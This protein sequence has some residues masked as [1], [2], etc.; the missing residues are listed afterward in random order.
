VSYNI[1]HGVDD[2]HLFEMGRVFHFEE[3]KEHPTE[4]ERLTAVLS[5][6]WCGHTWH[7]KPE[8]LDFFD[9]KGVVEN[10]LRELAVRKVAFKA[11]EAQATPWL[12]GGRA[13]WV[14]SS[15]RRLGWLG[16]VH[17]RVLA[18]FDID[19]S[20]VAFE[21]DVEALRSAS[22]DAREYVDIPQYPAVRLDLSLLLAKE[23]TAMDVGRA[24]KSAGG[25]L[26]REV[27][28]F[29]VFEDAERLG[30]ERRSMAFSLEYRAAD[31]TLSMDEVEKVHGRLVE[32]VVKATGAEIR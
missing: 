29:D 15:K 21:F 2:V 13:A 27:T 18:A 17:P 1:N 7:G 19:A 3:G 23:V 26:L 6:S 28:L 10:L 16:E 4:C 11:A 9:G 20:V 22:N 30:P 24:M 31:R 8:T 14:S 25:E 32:K 5:G 12:Q